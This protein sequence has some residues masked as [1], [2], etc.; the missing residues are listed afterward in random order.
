MARS[1]AEVLSLIEEYIEELHEWDLGH[2][3]VTHAQSF[4]RWLT[5]YGIDASGLKEVRAI[6]L[7]VVGH[8][9][10]AIASLD[11][12][13]TIKAALYGLCNSEALGRRRSPEELSDP[14]GWAVENV[15]FGFGVSDHDPDE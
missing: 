3:Y 9:L 4:D 6:V 10:E 5:Q 15:R 7:D 11:D 1:I 8:P 2:A 14:N 13:E 12:A